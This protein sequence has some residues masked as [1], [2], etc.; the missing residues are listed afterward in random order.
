MIQSNISDFKPM[1]LALFIKD[2]MLYSEYRPCRELCQ[3]INCYWVS[4]ALNSLE[5]RIYYVKQEIIT[6]MVA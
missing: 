2:S 6:P 3:V 4:P 5:E 1:Y